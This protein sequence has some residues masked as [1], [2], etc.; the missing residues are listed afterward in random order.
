MGLYSRTKRPNS[1]SRA[2][3]PVAAFGFRD[4]SC[5]TTAAPMKADVVRC[6]GY[7]MVECKGLKDLERQSEISQ[8]E[9]KIAVWRSLMLILL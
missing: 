7:A 1:V 4:A 8:F 6:H 2:R 9:K 3:A 5:R